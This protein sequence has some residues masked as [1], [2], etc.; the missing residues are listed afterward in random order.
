M[1]G[2]PVSECS[3]EDFRLETRSNSGKRVLKW[4]TYGEKCVFIQV[5]VA[6]F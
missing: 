6:K 1:G 2:E 5:M 3:A 4:Q